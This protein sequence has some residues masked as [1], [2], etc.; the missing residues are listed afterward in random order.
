MPVDLGKAMAEFHGRILAP[1]HDDY[2]A[3][4]V[5]WKGID[6]QPALIFQC[7]DVPD[8][9]RV[10]EYAHGAGLPFAVAGAGHDVAG[11]SVPDGG[12]V[13]ST[14]ALRDI[15]ID[16]VGKVARVG[17]GVQWGELAAAAH[18]HALATTGAASASVGV[19]GFSLH[20]GYG[21]LMRSC[22]TGCD[23]IIEVD[24]VT[25][26]GTHRTV[27]QHTD[28]DLLWAVRGAGANFGVVTSFT[29]RLHSVPRVTVGV[30]SYPV[31]QAR[32]VLRV[33]REITATAPNELV[34]DFYYKV[35]PDGTRTASI[36]V[37]FNGARAD[38]ERALEPLS[39]LGLPWREAFHEADAVEL[40]ALHNTSTPYGPRYHLRSHYLDELTDE[41]I[42][43]ILDQ[44][45]RI[46]APLTG[47]F[48]EHL[49]GA[50][51]AVA[52]DATSFHGREARYS[53]LAIAGWNEPED[54]DTHKAWTRELSKN[55]GPLAMDACYA[56]YLDDDEDHRIPSAYGP[57]YERLRALKQIYDPTDLL[58]GNRNIAPA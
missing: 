40:H 19:A 24:M 18:P 44:G 36:G 23:N 39:A 53:F 57:G 9:Q 14:A 58:R 35:N 26:D 22:G 46:T 47:I 13:L 17:A 37:C 5:I 54:D 12:I 11:R 20:G 32:A 6:R 7:A 3:A 28:P 38:A 31:A 4:R 2:D 55:L 41:V 49:G 50:I 30:V 42:D 34:T 51:A 25:P 8:I 56:N 52:P 1:G 45:E 15:T 10:L 21:L 27:N 16:P 33:Y 43:L 48:L 29:L